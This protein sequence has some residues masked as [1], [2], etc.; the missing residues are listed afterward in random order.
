MIDARFQPLQDWPGRKRSSRA[1]SPFRA[2]YSHTLD[3]LE[4]E[5]KYLGG[6]DIV[7]EAGFKRSDIRNDGWPRSGARPSEPGVILNFQSKY[8]PLRI[9]CDYF[10]T[11]EDNVRAIALH[12]EHLRKSALY[13]VASH[14]EQYRGWMALPPAGGTAIG[15]STEAA[16]YIAEHADT[17][18][19]ERIISDAD[20]RKAM[21]RKGIVKVHP[22]N[23]D[24]GDREVFEL[25][26]K[27]YR[28]LEGRS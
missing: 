22:D 28:Y 21:Y 13:G 12:L 1:Y 9:P 23:M 17:K 26:T 14:G 5:L 20:Y 15:T 8:G 25:L 10:R 11:W 27:S 16:R 18:E 7:I 4:K 19:I 24:T 6:K 3:L 2:L